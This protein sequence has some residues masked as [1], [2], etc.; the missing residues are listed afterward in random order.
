MKQRF[1]KTGLNNW[2]AVN[3]LELLL[4][5]AV[6]Q[7]DTN[8]IAH[9]LLNRFGSLAGVLD[10]PSEQLKKVE[11]VGDSVV[12]L[13]K[14]VPQLAQQY[15]ISKN[16][17]VLILD[18]TSKAG[19][20]LVPY[21][22]GERDEVVYLLC[23]DAKCKV[24]TCRELFRGG[25]NSAAVSARKIVEAAIG[26]NATSV[27]LAHNHPSGVAL[28]SKEDEATT[29]SIQRALDA[30]DILLADHIVVADGDFVS[31]ADNGFFDR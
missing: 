19:S 30:V 24:L 10:A 6:P 18:T 17:G 3:I 16:D 4:F 25:I 20:Y 26:C 28:P 13:L 9:R 5:Y 14:L 1:L 21:F 8:P 31:M 22:F 2:D 23:L 27:V 29:R 15:E 11:G 12:T 7:K